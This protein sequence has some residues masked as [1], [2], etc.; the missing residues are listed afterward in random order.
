[1]NGMG[2]NRIVIDGIKDMNLKHVFDCGQC[3]RWNESED[4]SYVGASGEFA[5]RARLDEENG[6]L[7]LD[8][9]GGD[10]AFW[11]SYFDLDTDYGAIKRELAEKEP[12][13]VVA[14]E[15]GYGIR[16]L[17]QDFFEVLISFI[18]SQNNNIPRIKKNIEAM[19]E[20]Y[21]KR[22]NF[23]DSAAYSF[24]SAK[25]L[26]EVPR[27]ELDALKL[28]YRSEYIIRASQK[29]LNEGMPKTPESV[30]DYY[31]VG[32]KV[33]N[34]IKLFGLRQLD[35]FPIDTWVKKIMKDMYGFSENDV[36]GMQDFAMDRFGAN[37]GIAQQYLF[38]YYRNVKE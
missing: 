19:C 38:N 1:M 13:I 20:K 24:P 26:A 4:G 3:F 11:R 33:A 30:L 28:G 15:A 16:I 18:I 22:I 17:R 32:P 12:K 6:V 23:E 2:M 31:G 9:S 10:E 36:K 5:C 35:A 25:V 14:E 8:A 37:G 27:E 34:C 21:G 7:S 29:F